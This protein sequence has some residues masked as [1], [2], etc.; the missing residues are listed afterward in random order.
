MVGKKKK[1]KEQLACT[2][3]NEHCRSKQSGLHFVVRQKI[4]EPLQ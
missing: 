4:S 3:S 1:K 2:E